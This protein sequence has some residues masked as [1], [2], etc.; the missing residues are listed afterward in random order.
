[1]QILLNS[2]ELYYN[3]IKNAIKNKELNIF[4]AKI[5]KLETYD[6]RKEF[7]KYYFNKLGEGSSRI[8]YIIDKNR[9]LKLAKNDKGIAQNKAECDH[10]RKSKIFNKI[11]KKSKKYSYIIVE[12]LKK[13]TEKRF[14]KLTGFTFKS[15]EK[16]FD[17]K[18][19]SS[20]DEPKDYDDISKKWFFKELIKVCENYSLVT[21]DLT[22]ISSFGE[23]NG[24]IILIDSGLTKKIYNDFY[25]N[26][27]NSS[28]GSGSSKAI[29]SISI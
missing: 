4:L 17:Y 21:G 1:M 18:M 13:L 8:V 16:S 26:K 22:K 23:R 5:E 2:I 3:L 20:E 10:S 27:S 15:F 14:K 11:L 7:A 29:S 9:L 25:E 6:E 12:N 28:S 19:G 24:K